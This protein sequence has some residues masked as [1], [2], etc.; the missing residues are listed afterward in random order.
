LSFKN[1]YVSFFCVLGGGGGGG[2]GKWRQSP[3][4]E[5]QYLSVSTFTATTT[6]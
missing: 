2:G 3:E 4:G 1:P 6:A 5:A